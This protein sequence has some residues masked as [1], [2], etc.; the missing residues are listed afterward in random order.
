MT[1]CPLAALLPKFETFVFSCFAKANLDGGGDVRGGSASW[2][3]TSGTFQLFYWDA[4]WGM[5]G[6]GLLH[7]PETQAHSMMLEKNR[8]F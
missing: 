5:G 8:A 6:I 1:L 4:K 3:G 7:P 2:T